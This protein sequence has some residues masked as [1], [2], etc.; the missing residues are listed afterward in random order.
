EGP[1]FFCCKSCIKKY[2]ASPEKYA[3]KVASQRKALA[4]RAKVQVT[5]PVSGKPVDQKVFIESGDDKVFFCC[6]GCVGKYQAEPAK[7]KSALANG[8]SYQT[9]CPVMGEPIDPKASVTV[10]TGQTIYFCCKGCDK[11]LMDNPAK[12]NKNLVAQGIQI[13][14][15]E[16]QKGGSGHDHD[17]SHDDGG[18]GHD[19]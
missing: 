12:Y 2:Q 8:Y 14:W 6:P 7:Y 18:H 3:A 16:V 5:C 13:N 1:V 11:K 10:S 19:H 15:A 4:D 9:K 17:G